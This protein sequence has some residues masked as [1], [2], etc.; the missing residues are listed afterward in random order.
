MNSFVGNRPFKTL[1]LALSLSL[2]AVAPS[3]FAAADTWS[4]GGTTVDWNLSGNWGGTAPLTGDSLV[5]GADNPAGT[6]AFDLLNNNLAANLNIAGITF[7]AGAP[8]YTFTG[9]AITLT[10]NILNSS[11]NLQTINLDIVTTAVRTVTLTAGGGNITL[12]GN[13]TG[14]GGGFTLAGNGTLTLSG[15][16]SFTGNSTITAGT[17]KMASASALGTA[18]RTI[19]FSGTTAGQTLQYAS[20]SAI[21]SYNLKLPAVATTTF[22]VILDRATAGAAVNQSI[23][24][25]TFPGAA[26]NVDTLNATIGANVTSGTPKL[27]ITSVIG[28]SGAADRVSHFAGNVAYSIGNMSV[29]STTANGTFTFDGTSLSNEVTGVISNNGTAK[30]SVTVNCTV[31]GVWTLSGPNTYTGNTTVTSG[32]L[33]IDGTTGNGGLSVANGATFGRTATTALSFGGNTTFTTGSTIELTL[34]NGANSS[35]NRASGTWTFATNEAFVFDLTNAVAGSTYHILTGLAAAPS[36]SGWTWNNTG[37]AIG[38]F[39]LNGTT[40]VDFNLTTVP[41]P[42]TWALLAFSLTTGLVLRR[43]RN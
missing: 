42:Q 41:E 32:T 20:D 33:I 2:A 31:T 6:A 11:T 3:A 18:G 43:R 5:F 28:P 17:I 9:N 15:N 27:T 12:G 22:N 10:G 36:I 7:N 1:A 13:I 39:S 8:A 38:S 14:T 34:G 30:T 40:G 24:I 16:N 37:G 35:I 29:G 19:S 26:S 23:G 21:N 4:T 25:L